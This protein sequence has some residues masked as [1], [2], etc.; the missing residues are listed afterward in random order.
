MAFTHATRV[1]VLVWKFCSLNE[2]CKLDFIPFCSNNDVWQLENGESR[3]YFVIIVSAHCSD[4]EFMKAHKLIDSTVWC[5]VMCRNHE[6]VW[7]VFKMQC[8][9]KYGR[10]CDSLK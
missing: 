9:H 4:V 2:F 1:R 3:V 6:S 5:D 8:G 7:I 10:S